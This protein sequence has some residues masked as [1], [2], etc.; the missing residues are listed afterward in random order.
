MAHFMIEMTHTPDMCLEALDEM[1]AKESGLLDQIWW[2]CMDGNHTGW[3]VVEACSKQEALDMIPINALEEV[4]ITEVRKLTEE[5][6]RE[7]HKKLAAESS[8]EC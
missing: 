6:I 1:A 5:D 8:A 2:G 3:A 4:T 7:L